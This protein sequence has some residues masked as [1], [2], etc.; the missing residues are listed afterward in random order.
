METP[1]RKRAPGGGRKP[2]PPGEKRVK[3]ASTMRPDHYEA[4]AG[5][6]RA[7]MIEEALDFMFRAEAMSMAAMTGITPEEE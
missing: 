1:K 3:F 6:K 2:K 7:A 5:G 4:T